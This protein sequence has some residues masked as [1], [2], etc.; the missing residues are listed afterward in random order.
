MIKIAGEAAKKND[1]RS[2]FLTAARLLKKHPKG[3]LLIGNKGAEIGTA[4]SLIESKHKNPVLD[5][6]AV[7]VYGGK[8]LKTRE[9]TIGA[10]ISKT[11]YKK[12]CFEIGAGIYGTKSMKTLFD[13]DFKKGLNIAAGISG[14]WKF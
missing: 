3:V 10:G 1:I 12:D 6:W 5:G 8:R 7:D 9:T 13:R 4:F 14:K 2:F 11:V